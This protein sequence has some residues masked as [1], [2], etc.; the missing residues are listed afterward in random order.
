MIGFFLLML[1]TL[2]YQAFLNGMSVLAH[3]HSSF[4]LAAPVVLVLV[5]FC[6]NILPGL[7]LLPFV[8]MLLDAMTGGGVGQHLV[9][10]V[11]FGFIGMMLSSWLGK[12]HSPLIFAFLLGASFIYRLWLSQMG[13]WGFSNLLFGP[14][15]DALVGMLIFYC[16]P[17]RV[18]RMD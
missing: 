10:M 3:A 11:I 9:W 13:N 7:F 8:G 16:L 2:F 12:P 1:F 14:L 18:I 6:M 17:T 5:I 15:A 4:L